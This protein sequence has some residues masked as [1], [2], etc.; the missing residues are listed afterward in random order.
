MQAEEFERV[1]KFGLPE[2]LWSNLQI[3]L[4]PRILW[5]MKEATD[6]RLFEQTRKAKPHVSPNLDK[7]GSL[8]PDGT[9]APTCACTPLRRDYTHTHTHQTRVHDNLQ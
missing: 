1:L 9:R 3:I 6:K 7:T 4:H 5:I 2:C 8:P